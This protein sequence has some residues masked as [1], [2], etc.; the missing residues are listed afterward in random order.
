MKTILSVA[1]FAATLLG[2]GSIA[3]AADHSMMK[4]APANS[5]ATMM[6]RPA[7]TGETATAMMG[8]KGIVCKTID[9][10]KVSAM[11]KKLEAM[12]GG[13]KAAKEYMEQFN[14]LGSFAS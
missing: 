3:S 13:A 14:D 5:M 1:L 11:E 6:C 7:H 9:M 2:A 12:P 4:A 8:A 10:S